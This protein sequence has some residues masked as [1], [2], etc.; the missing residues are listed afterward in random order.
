M[1]NRLNPETLE[2]LLREHSPALVLYARQ[3]TAHAE[4]CVQEAFIR[5]AGCR[6]V[7]RDPVCWLYRVTRNQA[8]NA[9]RGERRRRDRERAAAKEQRW[10]RSSALDLDP[11]T[12][13]RALDRLAA[14]A[15]EIVVARIWGDLTFEQIGRIVGAGSSTVHRKYTQSLGELRKWLDETCTRTD[16]RTL[17]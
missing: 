9:A 15:R 3:W 16:P 2:R 8:I 10:V 13:S 7:P 5:L 14:D 17:N 4:D 1:A 11:E 12:V 6:Q